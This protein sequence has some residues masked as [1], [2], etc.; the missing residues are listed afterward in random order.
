[1]ATLSELGRQDEAVAEMVKVRSTGGRPAYLR[2]PKELEKFI[3]RILPYE[4]D[5]IRD[6]LVALWQA[7]EKA[8]AQK[9]PRRR[10]RPQRKGKRR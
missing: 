2:D 5:K 1:V 9:Q 4:D 6:R 7:A 3:K 8:A 10:K